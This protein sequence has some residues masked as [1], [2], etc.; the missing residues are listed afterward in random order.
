LKCQKP[1]MQQLARIE[2]QEGAQA[3]HGLTPVELRIA[4]LETLV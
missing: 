2:S 3:C 1:I 4:I